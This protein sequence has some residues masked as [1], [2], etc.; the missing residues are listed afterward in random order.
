MDSPQTHSIWLCPDALAATALSTRIGDLCALSGTPH[1][2]PHVTL[3]GDIDCAPAQTLRAVRALGATGA[4]RA[5]V[6]DVGQTDQFFM[7]LF[8]DLDLVPD[9]APL[10]VDIA[11]SLKVDAPPFRPHLSL[12]YGHAA[13][14]GAV[15]LRDRLKAAYLGTEIILS[16]IAI[17]ASSSALPIGAWHVLDRVPL[18]Q[19]TEGA[20]RNQSDMT[21]SSKG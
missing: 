21:G 11:R 15:D 6:R 3:L 8:L 1:F 5:R 4:L 18:D 19:N 14:L 9:P 17:V 16:D 7:A 10:R 12:A 13:A 20:T 2:A